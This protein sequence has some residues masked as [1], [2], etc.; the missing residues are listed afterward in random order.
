MKNHFELRVP[1][2]QSKKRLD[3]YVTT[4]VENATR[5]KVQEAIKNGEIT[6]NGNIVK[7]SYLLHPNDCIA[8]HLHR[9]EPPEVK[10]EPIPLDIIFEDDYLMVVNKPAGMVTHP[11]YKNYSGTLVNA[12]MHHSG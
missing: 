12:L 6:V 8:V 4:H 1:A 9:Q 7:P 3:V 10:P 11:A 5:S 2:G